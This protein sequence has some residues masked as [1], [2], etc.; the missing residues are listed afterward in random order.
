L[1]IEVFKQ[2]GEEADIGG[3]CEVVDGGDVYVF[4]VCTFTAIEVVFIVFV[5][6]VFFS[7]N[8]ADVEVGFVVGN[9][10]RFYIEDSAIPCH[11]YSLK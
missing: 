6:A 7:A 9:C 8:D 5:I 2:K 10:I 3:G 11:Y 1:F 4:T